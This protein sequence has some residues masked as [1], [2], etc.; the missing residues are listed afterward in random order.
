VDKYRGLDSCALYFVGVST[1]MILIFVVAQ[2]SGFGV[3]TIIRPTVIAEFL[4][5]SDFSVVAGLLA[6]GFVI[7]TAIAPI[8]GSLLWQY[9]GYDFVIGVTIVIPLMALLTFVRALRYYS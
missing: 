4:G 7:G 1:W 5:R 6:M 8:F 9:G 2:G 3:I